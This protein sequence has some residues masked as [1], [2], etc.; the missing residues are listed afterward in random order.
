MKKPIIYFLFLIIPLAGHTQ[1]WKWERKIADNGH[2]IGGYSI[3]STVVVDKAGNCYV[4]IDDT[5]IFYDG[6]IQ[7]TVAEPSLIKI[8][9]NGNLIWQAPIHLTQNIDSLLTTSQFGYFWQRYVIQIAQNGDIMVCGNLPGDLGF[10]NIILPTSSMHPSSIMNFYE[11][12]LWTQIFIA[13]CDTS[14]KWQQANAIGTTTDLMWLTGIAIDHNSNIFISGTNYDSLHIA[15]NML[16]VP[17][18]SFLGSFKVDGSVNWLDTFSYIF[19]NENLVDYN[20][21]DLKID[22]VGNLFLDLVLP[23]NQGYYGGT[24]YIY[25]ISKSGGILYIKK[26]ASSSP[27]IN[28]W[29]INL[30]KEGDIYVVGSQSGGYD[31]G[32]GI[33][34]KG[35]GNSNAT[36]FL[37]KYDSNF[38]A[39]WGKGLDAT[40]YSSFNNICI[41]DPGNI[42]VSGAFVGEFGLGDST[43]RSGVKGGSQCIVKYNNNGET[44]LAF[45]FGGLNLS[46]NRLV[47]DSLNNLILT[48]LFADSISFGCDSLI[49]GA[50]DGY[51]AK[52]DPR[53]PVIN[54]IPFCTGDSLTCTS[55]R[56]FIITV[57]GNSGMGLCCQ[58]R[59]WH[60]IIRQKV[61]TILGF[62]PLI[63]L[64]ARYL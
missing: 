11:R 27:G 24:Y 46:L 57:L 58:E 49:G 54:I 34:L 33:V 51:I 15:N 8:S 64:V 39:Q 6:K 13:E 14:G 23:N 63:L 40:G 2:L 9:P 22:D 3:V 38:N 42:Y 53:I 35:N 45:T 4:M 31:F 26:L 21:N 29:D 36:S 44:K 5:S 7:T 52:L 48:G 16:P 41:D 61:I 32:N 25:K 56:L 62:M 18:E 60:I 10:G 37:V 47:I 17:G 12:K 20:V 28:L 55:D 30:D 59:K 1:T 50:S 19:P 43:Y